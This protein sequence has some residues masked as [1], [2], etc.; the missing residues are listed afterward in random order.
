MPLKAA[1]PIQGGEP[2]VQTDRSITFLHIHDCLELGYCHTGS[3]VF[4]VGEKVIPY[5]AGDVSFINYTE[6]HLASSA[7]GTHSDWSWIYLDPMQ[8]VSPPGEEASRFDVTP[9]AGPDFNNILSGK[10]HPAIGRVVLR[11]IEELQGRQPGRES[12]LRALT[13]ELMILIHRTG[14]PAQKCTQPHDYERLAPALQ[15]ITSNYASSLRVGELARCCGL[16]EPHFR[17]LF[18][19]T[20][21]RSPRTYWNDLR[22][23]MAASLLRSTGRSVLEISSDVGFETLSSFNRL[24]RTRFGKPPRS[25][26]G[27]AGE[28]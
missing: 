10:S 14:P 12:A 22:L 1:F 18:T 9:L 19:R 13:W 8:L 4:I 17:R 16:S 20:I 3:G 6:V 28:T 27:C 24:F 23:R 15:M 25:W 11:M 21:G 2:N 7:P 5:E 26:R